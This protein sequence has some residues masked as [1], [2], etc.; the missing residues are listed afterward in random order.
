MSGYSAYLIGKSINT[1]G[2][3]PHSTISQKLYRYYLEQKEVGK[4]PT[5]FGCDPIDEDFPKY[6]PAGCERVIG[7]GDNNATIVIGRD[8]PGHE[9]TGC[10]GTGGTQCG[11]IDLVAGRNSV[12][13]HRNLER[14][15]SL[16]KSK[17]LTDDALNNLSDSSDQALNNWFDDAAR[18]YITQRAANI[19]GYLGFE[20]KAGSNPTDLSAVVVK[21]D[22][23]RIVGRESVRIYAGGAKNVKNPE[24]K[25][26]R[27]SN[28]TPIQRPKIELIVGGYD[29]QLQPA[30]LGDQLV[31]HL[32]LMYK[33]Q[34]ETYSLMFQNLAE[35]IAENAAS[36]AIATGGV[37]S[38]NAA[39]AAVRIMENTRADL[40]KQWNTA[41]NEMADLQ[42]TGFGGKTNILSNKV[43]IT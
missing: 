26:E 21:S 2:A 5:G 12:T 35:A 6:I 38:V 36:I 7:E 28:N 27:R 8:R 4:L 33:T 17:R 16:P 20:N 13:I 11:M 40:T 23:T 31:K 24:G 41:I 1:K 37:S 10:G 9:F 18:V 34:N 15:Y 29:D 42:A 43:Y 3:V 22:C 19:D 25:G 30:V 32:R 39:K 14:H